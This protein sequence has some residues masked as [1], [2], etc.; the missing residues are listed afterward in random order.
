MLVGYARVAAADRNAAIQ[1]AALTAAG[2][3]RIFADEG[4]SGGA[5]KRPALEKALAALN[6]GDVLVVWR[7]DRLGRSLSHLVQL[8]KLLGGG[9]IGFKSLSESIDTAAASGR[10]FFC[11]MGALAD[12]E[13]SLIIERTRAGMVAA[14][15]RGAKAGRKP[16]LTP[17]QIEYARKL[18]DAGEGPREVA[19]TLGVGL[20]TLYRRIPAAASNRNTLDLFSAVVQ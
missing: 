3:E 7:L 5:I 9:G 20:A 19:K 18:I 14:R 6:T 11:I 4:V 12:F 13:R 15:Q 16:K 17:E 1:Q 2:C 10:Q 8:A